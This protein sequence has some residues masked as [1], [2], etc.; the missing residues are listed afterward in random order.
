VF[1]RAPGDNEFKEWFPIPE[2]KQNTA[3]VEPSKDTPAKTAE[4][5]EQ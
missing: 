1:N 4:M 3:A 5:M 2:R